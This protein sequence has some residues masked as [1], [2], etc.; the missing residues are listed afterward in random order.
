MEANGCAHVIAKLSRRELVTPWR[1]LALGVNW[2]GDEEILLAQFEL[3][4]TCRL[5]EFVPLTCIDGNGVETPVA[6]NVEQLPAALED[7]DL[8]AAAISVLR[9]LLSVGQQDRLL[10]INSAAALLRLR[11]APQKVT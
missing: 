9:K 1:V 11:Q 4:N 5:H 8:S 7:Y 10:G 2:G 6:M 3:W